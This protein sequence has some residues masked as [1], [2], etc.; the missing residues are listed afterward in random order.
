[1]KNKYFFRLIKSGKKQDVDLESS[2]NTQEN[3]KDILAI[4]RCS[5]ETARTYL[6][7]EIAQEK[8]ALP[9]GII[10]F[11]G[12]KLLTLGVGTDSTAASEK[13]LRF[14]CG[15]DVKIIPFSK[16]VL[17]KA[18]FIAYHNNEDLLAANAEKLKTLSLVK[19]NCDDRQ[20]VKK[21]NS[22]T[23]DFLEVLI[24]YAIAKRASDIHL[25]PQQDGLFV[26]LRV[27]GELRSHEKPVCSLEV[28][29]T[30]VNRIKIMAG[31]DTTK[32]EALHDGVFW[33][34]INISRVSIRVSIIPTIH[35]E[36]TVL[37]IHS[38]KELIKLEDL[39]LDP[40]TYKFIENSV[41]QCR[42]I[43]LCAGATGSGKSTTLYAILE[44][45]SRMNKNIVTIEDP[46]EIHLPFAAQTSVKP[47]KGLG[48]AETLKSTLRQ[49]PDCIMIGELRDSASSM[50]AFDAALT[51]HLVLASIHAGC[52][53]DV[54]KRILSLGVKKQTF[55]ETCKLILY[56]ELVPALCEYCKKGDIQNSTT[57]GKSLFRSFGCSACDFTGF[58]GRKL[59]C[60]SFFL[61]KKLFS[62][63]N[64]CNIS[65]LRGQFQQENYASIKDNAARLIEQGYIEMSSKDFYSY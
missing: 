15:M 40:Q 56:Q 35:G 3:T 4:T 17:S 33:F 14:I 5:N 7:Y 64:I 24:T 32:K 61:S 19:A 60:E 16:E 21:I 2:E 18:I 58:S 46:V 20:P 52:V 42:G 63:K 59:V 28:Y 44:R 8:C 41:E 10:E 29:K 30:I 65:S 27:N 31:L 22:E 55:F 1:M 9:L 48:Y 6:P 37:R 39:G 57:S 25:L 23:N 54:F 38:T 47:D 12:R 50:M 51:G 26:T 53:D 49:D 45:I 13:E 43:I 34:D 62:E 36:K 11:S